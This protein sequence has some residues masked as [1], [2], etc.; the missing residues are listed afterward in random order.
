M[1]LLRKV[2][3]KSNGPVNKVLGGGAGKN[4]SLIATNRKEDPIDIHDQNHLVL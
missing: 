2:R 1:N 3:Q 4:S